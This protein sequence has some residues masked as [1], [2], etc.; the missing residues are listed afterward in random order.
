MGERTSHAP[1]TFSWTDLGTSDADGAKAFYG[2]LF[3]W[4]FEDMPVPDAPPY[5][6]ARIDGKAVC[7]VYERTTEQGPPAWLSYVT[8]ESADDSAARAADLGATVISGANGRHAGG[9]DGGA[10]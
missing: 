3:G 6:L 2:E 4:D 5:S 10:R 8:V 1:G 7:A 9:P